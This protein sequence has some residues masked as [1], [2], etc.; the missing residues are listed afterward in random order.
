[1]SNI[2]ISEEK[3]NE[4]NKNI[5][6]LLQ[7]SSEEQI[8]TVLVFAVIDNIKFEHQYG[9]LLNAYALQQQTAGQDKKIELVS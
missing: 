7:W 5:V 4:L 6:G 8:P 1:M 3:L 2:T 9:T